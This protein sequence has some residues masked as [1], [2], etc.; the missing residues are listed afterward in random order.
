M[1]CSAMWGRIVFSLLK[2]CLLCVCSSVSA[3]PAPLLEP[4]TLTTVN[5]L[6]RSTLVPC[7]DIDDFAAH[8]FANLVVLPRSESR[9]TAVVLP[10]GISV[11]LFGRFSGSLSSHTSL[12]FPSHELQRSQGPLHLSASVLLWPLASLHQSAEHPAS[13][14]LGITY[15]HELRVGPFS[16]VNI[17][18]IAS[19]LSIPRIVGIKSLGPFS[20]TVSVGALIDSQR[21]YLTGEAAAQLTL[22]VPTIRSLKVSVNALG[23]GIP[24]FVRGDGVSIPLQGVAGIGIAYQ[25]HARIDFAA[26]VQ[27]GFG[28]LAPWTIVLRFVTLSVG[29]EYQGSAVTPLA[30]MA[31]DMAA[32]AAEKLKEGIEELLRETYEELPIDPKLDDNCFI[33]DDNGSIMGK[34]GNRTPDGRFCEKD[35]A[36]VPIGQELW[37][38]KSGDRLCRESKYNPVSR[39]QELHDCVLWKD[40]RE[41]HAAHQ[42]RLN[43]RC[44]LRDEDGALLGQL[45][46]VTEGQRCRYPVE[47]NNGAYGK[48]TDYQEQPRDKIFYT[49]SERSRVC[50][51]PNLLR[52]FLEPAEGRPSLKMEPEERAA[53]GSNRAVENRLKSW[54]DTGQTLDDIASGR[55][56]LDT[57]QGD[58]ERKTLKVAETVSDRDK[59]KQFAK[60]TI[61]GWRKGIEEWSR[62]RVDDQLDD[63]GEWAT[64]GVIDAAAARGL[65]AVGGKLRKGADEVGELKKAGKAAKDGLTSASV[66]KS[67]SSVWKRLK[68]A[69]GKTKTDGERFYEWDHTHGDIEVYDRRGRHLGSMD[70]ATGEMTKAAVPGRK[71]AL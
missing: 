32:Y 65:G 37:R 1:Q 25:P 23:R 60:E 22:A 55:V 48:Y 66:S 18:G 21:T 57:V 31:A 17:L 38:D 63:L 67:D 44:E 9:S 51:T 5:P 47:R 56:N 35:G 20:L 29:R 15:D 19:D 30:E 43:E 53:R 14:R 59:L 61:S 28:G 45:G 11:G 16:G 26:E 62:K 70:A 7:L 40:K 2:L 12:W 33:R 24:S 49:D 42:A 27:R 3:A 39:L 13:F 6:C 54:Q 4:P 8:A 71:I 41:W 69:K 68:A 10:Y 52:C 58:I 34:F 46:S 64:D 36:K 50:E